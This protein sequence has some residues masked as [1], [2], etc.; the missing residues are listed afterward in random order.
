MNKILETDNKNKIHNIANYHC[1]RYDELPK[2]YVYMDQLI[3]IV[4]EY[5]APFE[6]GG[7]ENGI[8]VTMVN[9]Y[10]KR[11]IIPAPENKKYSR[12]H[13]IYLF[14]LGLLKN[15]FSISVI[16]ALIKNSAK[17]YPIDRAYNFFAEELENALKATFETRDFSDANS[18]KEGT[19]ISLLVHSAL[20]SFANNVYVRKNIDIPQE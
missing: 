16:G 18:K 20:L 7:E 6:V 12:I 8:T 3:L 5:L 2:F 11:K 13:I 15:V 9:N 4:N 14:V 10:V 19:K 17:E 1:P